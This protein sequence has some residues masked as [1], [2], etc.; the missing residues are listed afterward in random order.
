VTAAGAHVLSV[1]E[2]GAPAHTEAKAGKGTATYVAFLPGLTYLKPAYPKRPMDRG[3]TDDS[4][5]HFLPTTFGAAA[6]A[7]FAAHVP[8]E[9]PVSCTEPLVET[10]VLQA[11]TGTAIPLVNW[12]PRPIKGLQVTVRMPVPSAKV[13]LASGNPVRMSQDGNVI[14]CTLDLDTADGL[15]FRK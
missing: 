4:M 12:T 7:F 5:T 10:T 1:F 15:I 3:A 9:R 13:S 6:Q 11:K 14:Q 8:A 2:D